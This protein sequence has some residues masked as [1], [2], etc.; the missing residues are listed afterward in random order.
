MQKLNQIEIQGKVKSKITRFVKVLL[1][2]II[3]RFI[4][5]FLYVV[6]TFVVLMP[7]GVFL[8][9]LNIDY[10]KTYLRYLKSIDNF[11]AWLR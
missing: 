8:S 4:L 3:A 1:N 2:T 6:V 10:K 9:L 5:A 7:V 11:Q